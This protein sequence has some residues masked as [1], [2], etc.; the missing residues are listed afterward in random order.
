MLV[1]VCW[2]DSCCDSCLVVMF[3]YLAW[4]CGFG[5]RG[6]CF[7]VSGLF[8]VRG[9]YVAQAQWLIVYLVSFCLVGC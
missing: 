1:G 6:F 3:D 5:W 4:L 2:F 7:Y 8:W 9:L